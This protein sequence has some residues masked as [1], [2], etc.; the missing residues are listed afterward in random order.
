MLKHTA[1]LG[2]LGVGVL[3]PAALSRGGGGH[4]HPLHTACPSRLWVAGTPLA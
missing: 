3:G 2:L 4:S 1:P